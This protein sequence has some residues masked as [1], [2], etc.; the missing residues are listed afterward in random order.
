[1]QR[2]INK[3]LSLYS[4]EVNIRK[5]KGSTSSISDGEFDGQENNHK[6]ALWKHI[7]SFLDIVVCTF[8]V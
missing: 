1:M 5:V 4:S 8:S 6:Y 2:V 7:T 3:S